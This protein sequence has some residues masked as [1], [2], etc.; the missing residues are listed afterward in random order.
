[1]KKILSLILA[2]MLCF[3]LAA[4]GN[5]AES[6]HDDD[7]DDEKEAQSQ[8]R[9]EAKL[10]RKYADIIDL[11]ENKEYNEVIRQVNLMLIE[12]QKANQEPLPAIG[13]ANVATLE[14]LYGEAP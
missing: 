5:D 14:K 9:E 8:M 13:D 1:M 11:L 3:S 2:L 12:E 6:S 4:C 10:Y 7:D